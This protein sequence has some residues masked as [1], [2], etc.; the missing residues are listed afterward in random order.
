MDGMG[1][2]RGILPG[3]HVCVRR[4]KGTG[5][6]VQAVQIVAETATDGHTL[7]VPSSAEIEDIERGWQPRLTRAKK[8]SNG[9]C[10]TCEQDAAL[11]CF[12]CSIF[13]ILYPGVRLLIHYCCILYV[14]VWTYGSLRL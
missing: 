8:F 11:G 5:S 7:G 4:M 1:D 9:F 6:G 12:E 2:S 13:V 3:K 14:C 10:S